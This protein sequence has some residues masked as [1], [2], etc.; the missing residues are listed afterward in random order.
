MTPDS[1]KYRLLDH[2]TDGQA[3][4]TLHQYRTEGYSYDSI[5]LRL[6]SIYGITVTGETVRN[7]LTA[8]EAA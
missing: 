3:E 8:L 4:A 7:W 5:A 2:L 6:F 1:D